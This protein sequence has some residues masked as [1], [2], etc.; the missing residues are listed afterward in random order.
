MFDD[1]SFIRSGSAIIALLY[2]VKLVN[3]NLN[4]HSFK[5]FAIFT[6]YCIRDEINILSYPYSMI[7]TQFVC[8]VHT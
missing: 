2:P 7:H 3:F 6:T 8:T 5:R 1:D 4:T